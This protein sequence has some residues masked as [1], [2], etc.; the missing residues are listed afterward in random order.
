MDEEEAAETRSP[1]TA[2]YSR[3]FHLETIRFEFLTVRLERAAAARVLM[4]GPAGLARLRGK[5][6]FCAR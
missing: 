1:V 5:F 2:Y 4:T 6:R 3:L